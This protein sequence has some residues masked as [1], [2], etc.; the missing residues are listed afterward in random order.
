[1]KTMPKL[2][3][4]WLIINKELV[5]VYDVFDTR[6]KSKSELCRLYRNVQ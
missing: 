2:L 4:P 5:Y 1:M 6:C 3:V